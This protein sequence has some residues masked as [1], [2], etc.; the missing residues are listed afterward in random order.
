MS[1]S[2][3]A[4]HPDPLRRHQYRYWDGQ[5]WTQHVSD[6]GVQGVDPV[7]Q[8][9]RLDAI[10]SALT[11]GREDDPDRIRRQV[12]G[13]GTRRS[14]DVGQPAFQGGGTL[15]TE[16]VLVVNQK[17]KVIELNN[18]F[19]IFD[20]QGRRVG[21]VNE[22]GQSAAKKA[23]R[24]LTSYDQFLTHRYEVTDAHGNV[25]LR[26]TRPAKLMKSSVVVSDAYD[27]EI[28]RIVQENV[29]GK[30]RFDLQADGRTYGAI[31][32]ENWRAWNFRIEDHSGREVARITKTFEGIATTLFTTAD[33]YVVQVHEQLAQPLASLVVAAAVSVDTALKQDDRGFN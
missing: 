9:S 6:N 29:F 24:L 26:L 11:V 31:K 30:I 2:P 13:D 4:W 25:A 22:V 23:V 15:F 33:N 17:A 27:R 18:Q 20:A 1:Q 7:Q 10:D 16:P 8:Q 21:A 12:S 32:A 19:G 14:A 28:G 3:A 5:Q